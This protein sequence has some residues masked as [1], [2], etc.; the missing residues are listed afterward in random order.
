V[1]VHTLVPDI[2]RADIVNFNASVDN[3]IESLRAH[4]KKMKMGAWNDLG[5]P[6]MIIEEIDRLSPQAKMALKGHLDELQS[7]DNAVPVII[8][9]NHLDQIEDAVISRFLC[10]EWGPPTRTKL[11][12][13][14]K[15]ILAR[16]AASLSDAQINSLV[17]HSA[18][19]VRKLMDQNLPLTLRQQAQ[20][21]ANDG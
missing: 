4:F 3:G 13:R 11:I 12:T 15:A 19:D 2:Q 10:V 1:L 5:I 6:V 17:T 16:Q 20:K 21:R 18:G 8:T 14:I 9:T 7:R